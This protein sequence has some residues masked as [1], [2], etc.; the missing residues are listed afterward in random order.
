MK[1]KKILNTLVIGA[2]IGAMTLG[3]T[4]QAKA[5]TDIT[6][7]NSG[8]GSDTWIYGYSNNDYLYT[9]NSS[10][11]SPSDYGDKYQYWAGH[12]DKND[13]LYMTGGYLETTGDN[14]T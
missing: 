5:Q 10:D 14:N 6:I 2:L 8:S 3:T 12:G 11:V 7:N 9:K 13:R 4:N 1:K